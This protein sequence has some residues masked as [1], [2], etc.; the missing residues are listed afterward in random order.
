MKLGPVLP[1]M[2]NGWVIE[3]HE[4]VAGLAGR[5]CGDGDDEATT[6]I[7]DNSDTVM[8]GF[9]TTVGDAETVAEKLRVL[10][11]V[12]GVSGILMTF[13]DYTTDIDRFGREVVPLLRK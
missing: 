6:N 7:Y 4:T 12:E 8:L 5:E 13:Q 1:T 9:P 10:G 3:D 11:G 2:S